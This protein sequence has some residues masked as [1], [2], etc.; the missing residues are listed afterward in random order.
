LIFHDFLLCAWRQNATHVQVMVQASPAG[1][2]RA[3][4]V[5]RCAFKL[6]DAACDIFQASQWTID[7]KAVAAVADCGKELA[8]VFLPE[9]VQALLLGSLKAILPEDGL[10]V[11]LCLDE[12]LMDWPWEYLRLKELKKH[13]EKTDYLGLHSR[14]SL[15]REAPAWAGGFEQSTAIE[16]AVFA[17]TFWED[18]G[19]YW[20]VQTEYILLHQALIGVQRFLSVEFSDTQQVAG[21]LRQ[22]TPIFYYSGHSETADGQPRVMMQGHN[23]LKKIK[24]MP[25]EELAQLLCK[26]QTR[27]SFLGA[28]NSGDWALA[29]IF[30]EAGIPVHIGAQ[31]MVSNWATWNFGSK[32]LASLVIGLSLDEAVMAARWNVADKTFADGTMNPEWGNFMV[33][34]ATSDAVL[35]PRPETDDVL[36]A[37]QSAR[38][39]KVLER[40]FNTDELK[41]MCF[42]LRSADAAFARLEYEDLPGET[43]IEKARELVLFAQR[44]DGMVAL[45]AYMQRE[46]PN[47]KLE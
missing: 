34:M 39:L 24:W 32:M 15:V 16:R 10:R 31:G 44:R 41:A 35:F 5:V 46:R 22:P 3:P 40:S 47:E 19:D 4:L 45:V 17:G 18:V 12:R 42:D 37:Q 20:S 13:G 23:D 7:A 21:L 27:V 43:R 25:A 36:S 30:L 2:M 26:A 8:K 33:Y 14:I 6:F 38:V 29:R 28:C 9:P 11:R 1:R